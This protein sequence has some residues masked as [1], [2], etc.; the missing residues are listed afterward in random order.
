[1][2][3]EII[4]HLNIL[5]RNELTS[6]RQYFLHST[7]FESWGF[8]KL[9]EKE[10]QELSEEMMHV[11]KIS[12]RIMFLQGMPNFQETNPILTGSTVKEILEADLKLEKSGITDL[13]EAISLAESQKDYA[14]ADLLEHILRDEEGH[15]DWITKQLN[16]IK[17]IGAENYLQKQI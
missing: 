13:K 4:E 2:S 5:L 16:I 17:L 15:D 3:I 9:A 12:S 6:M 10:K 1:M 8:I 7:I 11:E 14:T